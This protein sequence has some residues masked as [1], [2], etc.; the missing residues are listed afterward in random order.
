VCTKRETMLISNPIFASQISERR[1]NPSIW[2]FANLEVTHF[3]QS[4]QEAVNRQFSHPGLPDFFG[5]TYQNGKNIPN[6]HKIFQMALEYIK[7]PQKIPNDHIFHC[8]SHLKL[9]K[10][11]FLF[12]KYATR[13]PCFTPRVLH[14]QFKTKRIR[15]QTEQVV[16]KDI[17][18]SF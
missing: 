10:L 6:N 13:Q 2:A 1:S 8:K 14:L 17:F 16:H 7:W 4:Q 18:Q 12:W 9:P 5:T 15:I 11:G 3:Q